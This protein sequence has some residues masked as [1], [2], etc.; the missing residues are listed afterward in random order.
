[1]AAIVTGV[2][3]GSLQQATVIDQLI[4][5]RA[6][7]HNPFAARENRVIAIAGIHIGQIALGVLEAT[8]KAALSI[9]LRIDFV[10]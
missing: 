5:L 10:A 2:D 9:Q 4:H 8:Q 3:A 6:V 1:M 7:A